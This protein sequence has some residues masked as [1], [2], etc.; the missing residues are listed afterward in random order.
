[1][2]Q[3]DLLKEK[4]HPIFKKYQIEKAILFGS[5]ARNDSTRHS[6]IDLIIIQNTTL[7]FL[8]RYDGIFAA[9]SQA[10]SEWDVDLLIYTP[11]ELAEISGRPFIMQILK[12]GKILYESK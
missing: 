4:L 12:E 11:Q 6:D 1:M 3:I 7:R 5:A 2:I 8:D 10:L 9:F